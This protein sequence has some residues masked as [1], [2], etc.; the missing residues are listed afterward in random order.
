M[1]GRVSQAGTRASIFASISVTD[2]SL[3]SRTDSRYPG[4]ATGPSPRPGG[5][6]LRPSA[7]L[8]RPRRVREQP[9]SIGV[10]ASISRRPCARSR[11]RPT[12]RSA[13]R[14]PSRSQH[15]DQAGP[16]GSPRQTMAS[17]DRVMARRTGRSG[18]TARTRSTARGRT[19]ADVSP[20][21][22]AATVRG[23]W[24]ALSQW[25]TSRRSPYRPDGNEAQSP[26]AYTSGAEVRR[27]S[28]ATISPTGAE[29]D[30]RNRPAR[31]WRAGRRYRRRRRPRAAA[32]RRR[33]PP[34][35]ARRAPRARG[36]AAP[37]RCP[38]TRRPSGG[39]LL[40]QH[41]GERPVGGLH[42]GHRA[43]RLARRR[44]ELRADPARADHHDVVLPGEDGAQPLGV[45]ERAQQMDAG[46]ALGARQLD[47]LGAGGDD[48][49]VVRNRAVDRCRV[50]AR[51]G[52]TP[53]TSQPRR[54]STSSASKSTSKAEP[55]ALPSSTA[56]DSGGR[57]Y[58]WWGSAP[59][60]VTLP[61]KPC[62][63]RATAVCTPA[64]PAPTITALRRAAGL[65]PCVCSL[66]R[67]P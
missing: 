51:E 66:T 17:A 34:R 35:R 58:G 42:D 64:M 5:G 24:R 20:T 50:R 36:C 65:R 40:G 38:R 26:T 19:R 39:H 6:A 44:G 2:T 18:R 31:P 62:S 49:D 10:P 12:A 59:I 3:P 28:S 14:R 32:S 47:R 15:T 29:L 54:S 27:W 56:L 11:G 9:G 25:W 46:Y 16:A 41:T 55:S 1:S 48:E 33:A 52:R 67:S 7:R 43:A 37:P 61:V 57:S 13:T 8:Q 30:A 4:R 60:R 23:P 53:V 22:F 45:V 21:M 63:R